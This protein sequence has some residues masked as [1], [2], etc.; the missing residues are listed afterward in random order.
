MKD[1]FNHCQL[2]IKTRSLNGIILSIYSTNDQ[3]S[4]ILFLK[5]G[6]LQLR[7]HLSDNQSQSLIFNENQLINNGEEYSIIISHQP[8]QTIS[9]NHTIQILI[10]SSLSL[11]FNVLILGGSHDV[12]STTQFIGCFSNIT[13]NHHPLLPEG[14]VKSARYDCFYEQNSLCNRQI[15]CSQNQASQFCGEND[16]SLVCVPPT[17]DRYNQGLI[18]YSSKI[19]SGENEQIYLTIF[20]TSSNSTLFLS[21]N[22]SIQVSIILQVNSL[23]PK[24]YS[25]DKTFFS[26]RIYIRV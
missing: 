17:L 11:L 3:H 20:T 1:Q 26:Y 8:S 2:S 18:Q 19:Q 12:K 7:Y 10:P 9:S 25:S 14:V 23:K 4:L 6:K 16:C 15:P 13:Y 24:I 5:D 22:G 21:N